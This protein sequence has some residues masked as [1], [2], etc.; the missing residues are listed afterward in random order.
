MAFFGGWFS[1]S[2]TLEQVSLDG[3]GLIAETLPRAAATEITAILTQ[4]VYYMLMP[5]HAGQVVTNLSI[6][7]NAG[8]AS[9]TFTKFGLYD[10]SLAL[11]AS[12]ADD[13]DH[14]ETSGVRTLAMSTPYTVPTTGSYY[15]AVLCVS[16]SMPTVFRGSLSV[17]SN[18]VGSG[19]RPW[20]H[21]TGQSDLPA[22]AV[23]AAAGGGTLA[24]WMGAS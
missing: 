2:N 18:A 11:V 3:Q 6:G 15:A 24:V 10:S 9:N 13:P 19:L 16:A 14:L 5:L 21:Q 20:A 8:G 1:P 7:I 22:T 4:Q 23:F 12:S 17:L